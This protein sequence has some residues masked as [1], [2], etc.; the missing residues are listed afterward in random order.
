MFYNILLEEVHVYVRN[1]TLR[2]LQCLASVT[3]EKENATSL[4]MQD[5][6]LTQN[7]S[8]VNMQKSPTQLI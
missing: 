4:I 6:V 3:T 2:C 7:M 5:Q 8:G 1:S